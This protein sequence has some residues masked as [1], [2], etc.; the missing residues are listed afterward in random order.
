MNIPQLQV[1]TTSAK[2]GLQINQPIQEIEQPK[3]TLSIE[4]PAAIIEMSTTPSELSL[5][6]T[7]NRAALD[8]MSM[9]RRGDEVAQY[10]QQKVQEGIARRAQE[11]MQLVKIENGGNPL[12]D[13]IK[14]NTD[15]PVAELGIR[16]VGNPLQL[17]R[18]FT[19]SQL[20]MNVTPQKPI[21]DAQINQPIHHYTPGTVTVNLE[22]HSSI[23]IDWKV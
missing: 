16:F 12:A 23:E 18:S 7:E 15:R 2:L 14:Q 11:G 21:I 19:P 1:Q 6:T 17:K 22:Q 13:M 9:F 4:Q 10:S 5:D 20:N 3:A 8:L